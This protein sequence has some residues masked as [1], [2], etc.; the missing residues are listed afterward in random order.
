MSGHLVNTVHRTFGHPR[1]SNQPISHDV[2]A[3]VAESDQMDVDDAGAEPVQTTNTEQDG[4]SSGMVALNRQGLVHQVVDYMHRGQTLASLCFY[5]FAQYVHLIR[6][7]KSRNK[8][9]HALHVKHPNCST[10]V[11]RYTPDRP[12]GIPRAVGASFPR[13]DGSAGHGDA[14]C[15]VMMAHFIPFSIA[16]PL[17]LTTESWE[18][19]FERTTF[20]ARAVRVMS[21][22]AA[23]SECDD[24]RDA[25]QLRRRQEEARTS[26]RVD[27]KVAALGTGFD[28][29]TADV[30]MEN[31]QMNHSQSSAETL[32]FASTLDQ[33]GWF[34]LNMDTSSSGGADL[35]ST[36]DFSRAAR[37]TWASEQSVLE[38]K[39][40][41]DLSIPTASR[42]I[43]ADQ[44]MF[45]DSSGQDT[46]TLD[47]TTTFTN[48]PAPETERLHWRDRLPHDLLAALVEERG[49]TTS[50]ALAFNIAGRRFFEQLHGI[51]SEPL[52]MLM[53]G[54]AGTGKTVVVRLLRELMDRFGKGNEIQFLAPTGKAASAIG[55]MTQHAAFGI[56]VHRRGMT[57]EEL[58]L[59][60]HDNQGKRMRFLQSSFAHVRWLFFDEVSMTSC[61]VFAE[62]DQSLRIATQ[63]LDEPF[64]GINVIFAGDL[65]QLP[66]VGAAPLYTTES[67]SS[68]SGAIRTK[69]GLGR[70]SWLSVDDVVEFTEQMRME[71]T[72]MAAALTRLRTRNCIDADT[73]LF[74]ENVLR[75]INIS[76]KG[77]INRQDMI[78][79]ASTNRTVRAL[80][81]K[82]AASQAA[83]TRRDLVTSHA[84]DTTDVPMNR[85]TR[86]S[87]LSYNGQGDTKVGMGRIPLY[88]GMPVIYRGPNKSVALG[89]TNGV[90]GTITGWNLKLNRHGLTTPVGA[91]VQFDSS[92]TW[93]LT[94]LDRGCLPVYPTST[95]FTFAL[96]D[97]I[98]TVR[99]IS[100]RQ[101]PLQPG[102]AMTVHS[103]QGITC[104]TGVVV[105]L[106]QGGFPAYVAASRAT[107][108][109][110]IHL[111]AKVTTAQLN[112]P[113]L[114]PPL[115]AELNRLKILAAAT[116]D[117][118][119]ADTWRLMD[120]QSAGSEQPY[121]RRRVS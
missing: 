90:F 55:G 16:H 83:S 23:L 15:S 105:D 61:E 77:A 53:H 36:T 79:L 94:G 65:C 98:T 74:N 99:R 75:P 71:D 20:P 31:L 59:T 28:N 112:T 43:L 118:H 17:K 116:Y 103:A 113:G 35:G 108:R 25:D 82:K 67:K 121:K 109:A 87:L 119:S 80:N 45:D 44:L 97:E 42:G 56:E 120:S 86:V 102:F 24:A 1:D 49:L 58:Q 13:S 39:A 91:I 22:W 10:H 6:I 106:R 37:R 66:P 38:A 40:K 85:Q 52:R 8:N 62:I 46:S 21:N 107:R 110:D 63:L 78:V 104:K 57:T 73:A 12:R 84:I 69:V 7:P 101:L 51:K 29:S 5:D 95:T 64:G 115:R 68:Q 100:R 3:P 93:S 32:K 70:L 48:I 2:A 54:E 76:D 89:I 81:E 111:I 9:H 114:P 4:A 92:A 11:H 14:F 19:A 33:G 30:V 18:S 96:H 47:H 41:A 50:Q 26:M 60:Q 34:G 72:E 117:K 27:A 88:I